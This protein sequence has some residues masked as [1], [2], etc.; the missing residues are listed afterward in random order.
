[1]LKLIKIYSAVLFVLPLAAGAQT[2]DQI[3]DRVGETLQTIIAVLFVLA[4]VV[5]LWGI[6]KFI[7]ASADPA[8]R[9]KA[10]GI[11]YWGIIGLAVMAAAWGLSEILI[12]YVFQGGAE[13]PEF[14]QPPGY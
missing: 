4:T 11:M 8:G 2:I 12:F 14:V 13:T 3:I 7:A 1:M 9:E 10:K 6:I 5:F